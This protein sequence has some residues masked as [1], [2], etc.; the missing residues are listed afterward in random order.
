LV[1]RPIVSGAVLG[2][3]ILLAVVFSF[4][5]RQRT[6]CMYLCPVSGFLS[7]Y[8]MTS[9]LELRSKDPATCK[10]CKFKNCLRGSEK[11]Y[12]C[13][14]F[15][16]LGDMDRNN[17]CGLCMECLKNCPYDNVTLRLR[18]FASDTTL[19]GYDEAWKAFIMLTLALVY[20]IVLLGPWGAVKDWANV[21]EAG[22]WAS[23]LLYAGLIV[24]GALVAFTALY[25]GTIWLGKK[26][27]GLDRLGTKELFIRYAYTLVP[28]GLLAWIAFSVPL[29]MVNGS[30]IL[31]AASDPMGWGWDLLGTG[32]FP[33]TPLWPHWVPYVQIPLLLIGLFYSIKRGCE[34]GLSLTQEPIRAVKSMTPVSVLLIIVTGIFLRLYVG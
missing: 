4:I 15:Q 23:F 6:F 17:Y 31:T 24:V 13:P 32:D 1:T 27:A 29:V 3:M 10:A 19:K 16:Y 9:T 11:N 20:S 21:S 5:Y 12:G 30:Y 34:I 25:S 33:W 14:W 18:P 2:S 8:S 7:L 26:L 28:L 22:D